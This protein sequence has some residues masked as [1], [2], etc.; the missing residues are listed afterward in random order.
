MA[1]SRVT[2]PFRG[3]LP[4]AERTDV[5]LWLL[6]L[7]VMVVDIAL[8]LVGLGVG[9]IETNP[10]ALFGIE[11]VGYAVL[12]YLKVPALLLGVVG[13]VT[14]SRPMR[15]LN[16]VGLAVPWAAASLIN[17]SLIVSAT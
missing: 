2:D 4:P 12:A 11:T 5:Y 14:L 1:H 16:L 15:R 10:V 6:V 17:L 8:T 7:G 13:W 9:L 3:G